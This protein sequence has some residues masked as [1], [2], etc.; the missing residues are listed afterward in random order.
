MRLIRK[1]LVETLEFKANTEVSLKMPRDNLYR[2]LLLD[3]EMV[4]TGGATA[5]QLKAN[6]LLNVIKN[7]KLQFN[8]RNSKFSMSGVDKY[9]LDT[10]ELETPPRAEAISG[11]VAAGTKHI[12]L[13]ID[14][15]L[16]RKLLSDWSA[17]FDAPSFSSV[18]LVID[19]GDANDLR[20]GGTLAVGA[21]SKVNIALIE[22]YDDGQIGPSLSDVRSNLVDIRHGV[23]EIPIKKAN[24]SFDD[25]AQEIPIVPTPVVFLS[26]MLMAKKNITDGNPTFAN[27]VIKQVKLVN[28][29]GGGIFILQD[30]WI[31]LTA[32]NKT[33]FALSTDRPGIAYMDYNDFR[34]G[35]LRNLDVEALKYRLTTNAPAANKEN[36]LRIVK[37]Y[38]PAAAQ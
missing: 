5:Q 33:E 21:G 32:L 9:F 15:A 34:Q 17:L 12:H 18:D 29:E 20:T 8:G 22:A 25:D 27:D 37:K 10:F 26:Q 4:L 24:N 38:I 35:G 14:F 7:I 3:F 31:S 30:D 19:W 36:A 23:E 16:N 11:A 1:N 2:T 28:T 13:A 6:G